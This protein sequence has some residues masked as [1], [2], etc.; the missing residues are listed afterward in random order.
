MGPQDD[1]EVVS[2]IEA[3][4]PRYSRYVAPGDWWS[5]PMGTYH[6]AISGELGYVC[7]ECGHEQNSMG[8]PCERCGSIRVV[9]A[10]VLRN[11][12]GSDWRTK[13]KFWGR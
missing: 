12:V 4:R 8:R 1:I 6:Q 10:E 5:C 13:I 11:L 3:G 9:S 7:N 2:R